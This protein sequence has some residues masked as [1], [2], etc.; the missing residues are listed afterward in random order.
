MD[1]G[2]FG[3]VFQ[4]VVVIGDGEERTKLEKQIQTLGLQNTVH[5]AGFVP[6]ARRYLK[7]FDIFVLPS[8]KEGFPYVLLEASAAEVAIIATLVGGIPEL[9][10]N[11]ENGLLVPPGDAPMLAKAISRLANDMNLRQRFA[12]AGIKKVRERFSFS[13]MLEKTVAVYNI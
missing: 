11:E 3:G 1:F 8:L 7:A 6:D 10:T 12:A 5:L 4:I 13:E 2:L 9:I